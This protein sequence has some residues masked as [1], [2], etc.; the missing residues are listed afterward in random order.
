MGKRKLWIRLAGLFLAAAASFPAAGGSFLAAAGPGRADEPPAPPPA[1][2]D[3]VGPLQPPAE[4][5][6]RA[7]QRGLFEILEAA[8]AAA[9]SGAGYEAARLLTGLLRSAP[10]SE[11]AAAAR[12]QL[13]D[14]EVLDLPLSDAT[15]AEAARRVAGSFR[16]D[17]EARLGLARAENL[18]E[19]GQFRDAARTF[20]EVAGRRLLGEALESLSSFLGRYGLPASEGQAIPKRGED[21]LE[22]LLERLHRM[23]RFAD[24][25]RLLGEVDPEAGRIYT[26]LLRKAYPESGARKDPE[27]REGFGFNFRPP[28][29]MR[30]GFVFERPGRDRPEEPAAAR[31]QPSVDAA[32]AS[33]AEALSAAGRLLPHDP[34]LARALLEL[35]LAVH[36]GSPEAAQMRELLLKAEKLSS[37]PGAGGRREESALKPPSSE[38]AAAQG[39]VSSPRTAG[40]D[41]FESPR[42]RSYQIELSPESQAQ[43][44]SAPKT[45]VKGTFRVGE[46]VL[47]E[48]GVRLK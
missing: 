47:S 16:R 28:G 25:E 40:E 6:G 7:R 42:V 20:L 48:V 34:S 3:T 13:A 37:T 27:E 12:R 41:P 23:S 46:E 31:K 5:R 17:E 26:S 19:F 29:G 33:A 38:G 24:Q 1:G 18:M 45:F 14:W 35:A 44:R 11:P 15:A 36:A 4:V 10:E 2:K 30:G 21:E 32:P 9:R 43:L 8:R 39:G 22:R